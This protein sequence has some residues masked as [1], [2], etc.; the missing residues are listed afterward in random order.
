VFDGV[1]IGSLLCEATIQMCIVICPTIIVSFHSYT[2]TPLP[3]Q[4][5]I[6]PLRC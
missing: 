2:A 3:L 1:V 6:Y 5:L 4:S